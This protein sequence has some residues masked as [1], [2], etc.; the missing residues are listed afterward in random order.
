MGTGFRGA[1]EGMSVAEFATGVG[2]DIPLELL[3]GWAGG[4]EDRVV[5]AG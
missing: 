2:K 5:E 1:C 3:M 4:D